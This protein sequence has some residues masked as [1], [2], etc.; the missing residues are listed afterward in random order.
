MTAVFN[1][2][3]VLVTVGALF[4]PLYYQIS[5]RG[6]WR[7]SPMGRHVMGY[8]SAAAL[9]GISGI[10]RV[11]LPDLPG[12]EYVR[13]FALTLAVI[14]IWQRNYIIIR[15]QNFPGDERTDRGRERFNEANR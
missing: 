14:F 13:I 2:L 12:Q 3:L 15:A 1:T 8:T 4:F 11:F 6:E 9:L 5:T 7:R 10:F